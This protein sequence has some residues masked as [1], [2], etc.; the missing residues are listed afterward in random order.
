M[1][2]NILLDRSGLFP[3]MFC[4][5]MDEKYCCRNGREINNTVDFLAQSAYLI[6]SNIGR[7]GDS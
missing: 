3:G 2:E 6:V 4:F 1:P 7:D 5:S